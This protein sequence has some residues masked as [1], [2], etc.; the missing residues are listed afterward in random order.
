MD[1]LSTVLPTVLNRRGI[2]KHATGALVVYTAKNWMTERLPHLSGFMEVLKLQE[3]VLHIS[4]GHSVALQECQCVSAE[5]LA[6]LRLECPFAGVTD[7]RI[8]RQ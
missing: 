8:V 3:G 6:Y 4:C 7:A 5:L 1:K 2:Q